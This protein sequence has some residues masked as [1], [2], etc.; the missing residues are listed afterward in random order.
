MVRKK[1]Q[2]FFERMPYKTLYFILII[3]CRQKK[4]KIGES[5]ATVVSESIPFAQYDIHRQL[6][7]KL[8]IYGLN[9]VFGLKIQMS[10]KIFEVF[11]HSDYCSF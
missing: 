3:V 9:A 7:Y 6:M 2:V 11:H 8:R 10:S 1:K 5:N 4:A